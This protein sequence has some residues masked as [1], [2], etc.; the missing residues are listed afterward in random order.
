MPRFFFDT[1][2]DDTLIL[3]DEGIEL[4]DVIAAQEE[5]LDAAASIAREKLPA[6]E[7]CSVTVELWTEDRRRVLAATVS[8]HVERDQSR[9]H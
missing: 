3:D 9:P 8:M 6:G 5:A 4:A 1:H 2:E 7:V